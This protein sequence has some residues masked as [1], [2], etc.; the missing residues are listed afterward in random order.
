MRTGMRIKQDTIGRD[1]KDRGSIYGASNVEE[2]DDEDA[3]L[4]DRG[5]DSDRPSDTA[6]D[7]VA[8]NLDEFEE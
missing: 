1:G 3:L 2:Y 5:Q 4:G 8:V 6:Y 7:A